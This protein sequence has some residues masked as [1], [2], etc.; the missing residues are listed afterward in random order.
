MAQYGGKYGDSDMRRQN[1]EY[2]NT[3]RQT[4]EFG[5]PVQQTGYGTGAGTDG[6]AGV[7]GGLGYGGDQQ[8]QLR[9][10]R[11]GGG[12]GGVLQRSGSSGSSS[13]EDDDQG[14]RRKKGIKEKIKEKIP[15][16]EGKDEQQQAGSYP[17]STAT[18]GGCGAEL[19]QQQEKKGMME[20]IKEKLPGHH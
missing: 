12:G 15:R 16:M 10:E 6:T 11:R 7:T 9:D 18:S 3:I 14:G 2:G 17:T 1:D 5:N 8:Q 19:G 13:S 20:K 4:D